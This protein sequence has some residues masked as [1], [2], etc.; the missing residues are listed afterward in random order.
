MNMN[1]IVTYF[2]D[3]NDFEFN[4]PDPNPNNY[5]QNQDTF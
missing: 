1:N 5:N 3:M 2:F 4:W